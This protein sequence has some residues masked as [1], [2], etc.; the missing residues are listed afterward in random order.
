MNAFHLCLLDITRCG[1]LLA[2]EEYLQTDA[3]QRHLHE[4]FGCLLLMKSRTYKIR[5]NNS[6]PDLIL[7]I[8]RVKYAAFT[9]DGPDVAV[10]AARY[11]NSPGD[12]EPFERGQHDDYSDH[13]PWWL[14][15]ATAVILEP[16]RS[17]PFSPV[18]GEHTQP[19]NHGP[20]W[21]VLRQYLFG[22]RAG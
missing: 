17:S 3:K 21:L 14:L 5:K 12:S 4:K 8:R 16:T 2:T 1:F 10:P 11:R 9:G 18:E 22:G 6:G 19:S 7:R 20:A 13:Q 15:V